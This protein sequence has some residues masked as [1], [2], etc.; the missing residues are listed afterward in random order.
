[1]ETLRGSVWLYRLYDVALEIDLPWAE[2]ILSAEKPVSRLKLSRVRPKALE[3]KNPPLTVELE[4]TTL[5]IG[6]RDFPVTPI[7]RVYDFGVLGIIL[8]LLLPEDFGYDD[9]K[10][11]SVPASEPEDFEYVFAGYRDNVLKTLQP[12][13]KGGL[14][15]F[16]EDF[17]VFFFEEWPRDWDLVPVLLAETGP[18]SQEMRRETLKN[19]FS[20]GEDS[21]V[22][23]WDSAFVYDPAGSTD[24]PDLLEF[25][26]AQL[27]E[28][29]YYDSVLDEELAAMYDAIEEA[30]RG[31]YRRLKKYRGIMRRMMELVVEVTETSE[32]IQN[33]LKVT[34]D[35][36]Y[37]R[38][39]A[40][41]LNIFR[42]REWVKS[43]ERKVDVIERN[44]T[45]L[46]DE[47]VTHRFLLLEVSIVLLIAF[48]I[49]IW[50]W[51][52]R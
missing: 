33:A 48:E 19:H 25:A 43:I 2:R 6:D 12:A 22:I 23:T 11:L 21:T 3:F 29:R 47:L 24:I 20:Y 30:G 31:G 13:L 49:I 16:A 14:T 32:H 8:R 46:S 36:F 37:A 18:I 35:V 42:V 27:L 34:E 7:A 9:L 41:A 4:G 5:R 50:L 28:L 17:V 10:E 38:V 45:M 44:Y 39:Y 26:N 15:G 40:A 51:T 52:L 1:M